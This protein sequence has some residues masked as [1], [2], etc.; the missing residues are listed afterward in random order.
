MGRLPVRTR[1]VTLPARRVLVWETFMPNLVPCVNCRHTVSLSAPLCPACGEPEPAGVP[2]GLCGE[3]LK[4][5]DAFEGGRS[6]GVAF[7]RSCI[8]QHFQFPKTFRC[9]DCNSSLETLPLREALMAGESL[10]VLACPCCGGVTTFRFLPQCE[11]CSL[12][13][14]QFQRTMLGEWNYAGAN[15]ETGYQERVH[16]FCATNYWARLGKSPPAP[17]APP[18]GCALVIGVAFGVCALF[19]LLY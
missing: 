16:E 3:R 1:P 10:P 2:C 17:P 19:Q 6:R 8:A 4:R 12:P 5:R 18:A 9:T 15:D 14:F 11:Y 7:H 13:I